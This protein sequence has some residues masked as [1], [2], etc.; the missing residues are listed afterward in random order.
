[1]NLC[2]PE[3]LHLVQQSN[4]LGSALSQCGLAGLK[5]C[6]LRS[7]LIRQAF[8]RP[9]CQGGRSPCF[10]QLQRQLRNRLLRRL[11]GSY[12]VGQLGVG[13]QQLRLGSSQP[14][15]QSL[16]LITHFSDFRA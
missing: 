7:V 3:P 2:A 14:S 9:F 15:R 6:D 4:T 12:Q 8:I 5:L 13:V 16:N 11:A 1:M 10:L